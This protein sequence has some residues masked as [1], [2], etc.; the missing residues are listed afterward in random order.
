MLE[1]KSWRKPIETP[2]ATAFRRSVG[3]WK[4]GGKGSSVM[5]DS[6][7]ETMLEMKS[8]RKPIETP[9]ATA[10]RRSVGQW[11]RGGKGSSVMADSEKE[12]GCGG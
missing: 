12:Y 3:Q 4:R 11:K 5:A 1:M 6:E 2:H 10:F 7:K 9:H 8:W